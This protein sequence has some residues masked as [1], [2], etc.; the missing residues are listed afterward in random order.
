MTGLRITKRLVEA[1][2]PTA[3]ESVIW[4]SDMAGFG[5]RVRPS[6]HMTYIVQY[7]AGTGR[8][9]PDRKVTLG[10]VGKLTPEEARTAARRMLGAVAQGQDPAGERRKRRDAITVAELARRFMAEHIGSKRKPRTGELYGH[11]LGTYVEPALGARKAGELSRADIARLH[12]DL[13]DRP[14]LAN[15]MLTVV[16]SL[17][18]WAGRMGLVED[19]FN[20]TTRL[21]RYPERNRDRYL[22]AAEWERLGAAIREAETVGVPWEPD[23]GKSVKHAPRPENRRRVISPFTAAA[24][25][26]LLFT[27]A[28]L[29]EILHLRWE[30]VDLGRGLLLLPDS[31]TGRKTIVLSAPAL[32]IL[33]ELPRAGDFVIAGD[34]PKKPRADLKRPWSLVSKRA[35]LEGVRIHDLRHSFASVGAGSGLG[36]PIIGKLL[37][38]TQA[39]T[40]QRYAH[41]DA[42]PLRRATDSIAAEIAKAMGESVPAHEKPQGRRP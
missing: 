26:L 20:P 37:G 27:G 2:E 3:R 7:R 29:R 32:L 6:G 11:I 14:Y 40:T 8:S 36:L 23:P 5:V 17:Y 38:H 28:R 41:L 16:S 1:L 19:A 33:A 30:Y 9:A 42:D 31:K 25:R 13:R 39:S 21:E 10:A 35:G 22:T 34:D 18:S 12:H 15:R 24:I 4:D